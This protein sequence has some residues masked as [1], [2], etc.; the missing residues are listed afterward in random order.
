MRSLHT[1]FAV[2]FII[3]ILTVEVQSGGRGKGRTRSSSSSTRSKVRSSSWFRSTNRKSGLSSSRVRNAFSVRS[4]LAG[5]YISQ[6]LRPRVRI[7][8]YRDL[9]PY[10]V[11]DGYRSTVENGSKRDYHYYLCP[12]NPTQ[13]SEVYCCMESS[14]GTHYCCAETS[15]GLTFVWIAA[16][17]AIAA[18]VWLI[19][20]CKRQ[21]GATKMQKHW[22]FHERISPIAVVQP[23]PNDFEEPSA[24]TAFA[25]ASEESRSLVPRPTTPTRPPIGFGPAEG[26]PL[27]LF[28]GGPS[29][30]PD[31]DL[32]PPPYPGYDRPPPYPLV[33]HQ[34]EPHI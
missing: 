21:R 28:E 33:S 6:L 5:I 25:S 8:S 22:A 30:P 15:W 32:P 3:L 27:N 31:P 10:T 29:A 34:C 12:D 16:G 17:V 26:S 11:C 23:H 24:P 18:V 20:C 14:T 7:H 13:P 19:C 2:C 4:A 1:T 9:D